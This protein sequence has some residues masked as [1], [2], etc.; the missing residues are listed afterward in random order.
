MFSYLFEK[1]SEIVDIYKKDLSEFAFQITDQTGALLKSN[2]NEKG[3]E[4]LFC[5]ATFKKECEQEPEY[6]EWVKM[7]Q[8]D[9]KT[10]EITSLLQNYPDLKKFF[11]ELI[12]E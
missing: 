7:F 1:S 5:E 6:L 9:A 10:E 2:P 8:L 3:I 12:S 11:E 4:K